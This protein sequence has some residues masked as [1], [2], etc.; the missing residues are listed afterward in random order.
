MLKKWRQP[1]TN[2]KNFKTKIKKTVVPFPIQL[3]RSNNHDSVHGSLT[4][5]LLSR[6]SNKTNKTHVDSRGAWSLTSLAIG[7]PQRVTHRLIS[8]ESEKHEELAGNAVSEHQDGGGKEITNRSR[9]TRSIRQTINRSTVGPSW[10]RTAAT[11][12][13]V[14]P[15]RAPK[16]RSTICS[17]T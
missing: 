3:K 7:D 14:E 12:R 11:R 15:R 2:P 8:R 13:C 9:D 17:K 4:R 6:K 16:I 1:D 5:D 10:T